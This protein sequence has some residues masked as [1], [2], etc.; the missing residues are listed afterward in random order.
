[1]GKITADTEAISAGAADLA[2]VGPELYDGAGV[3]SS[4][5]DAASGTSAATAY[6]L[7][8][9]QFTQ[10]VTELGG[11]ADQMAVAAAAAADCY[12]KSDRLTN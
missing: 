1:M 8:C 6:D 7:L 3:M 11:A 10:S 2:G 12:V 9:S 5:T 4:A